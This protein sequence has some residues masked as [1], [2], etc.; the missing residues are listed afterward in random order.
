M[1][2]FYFCFMFSFVPLVYG[3][4]IP[5]TSY[6]AAIDESESTAYSLNDKDTL[7]FSSAYLSSQYTNKQLAVFGVELLRGLAR[8]EN[9]LISNVNGDNKK[10][11]LWADRIFSIW[12]YNSFNTAYHEI[13]HGL[14]ARAYGSNYELTKHNDKDSFSK[15]E[16]FFKFFLKRLVNTS[17]ASCKYD[18]ELTD[19][20]ALVTAAAGMNNE[21]YISEKISRGFHER[22]NISFIESFAYIY[23]KLSPTLY[24]LSKSSKNEVSD[25][26]RSDDPVR[27]GGYY[28][29]LGISATKN[30]IALGGLVS[31]LLSGTTYSII[32]SAFS[33]NSATPLSF[34]NFQVPD[35]FSYV[36]SKGI[37]YKIASAY[38]FQPDL[39]ILF[40][41]E[42]VFHG[43]STTEVNLGFNKLFDSSLHNAN[44]EVVSTFCNGFNL[45]ASCSI[46]VMEKLSVNISAG[47]YSCRSMLGER[48]AK[49]MK[50]NKGRNS[51]IS[52]SVSY[53]Y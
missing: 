53:K 13:G 38:N 42:H 45:E 35:T 33:E 26:E 27:V 6:E 5:E 19:H 39:K 40:G 23:G 20:E 16:N 41:A 47:S 32:K 18:K 3:A 28:K 4:N 43:K 15:N 50:N 52:V 36:T 29:K 48:P 11:V 46:P 8:F 37:S 9:Y 17:R 44:V 25:I 1:K 51:D 31:T 7:T 24:A 30:D 21:V 10:I 2:K 49:N 14:K 22:K 12:I 34:H